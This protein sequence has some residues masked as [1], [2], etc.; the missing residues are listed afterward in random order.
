M[1][2]RDEQRATLA[3]WRGV[4]RYA[5]PRPMIE[6][7][8]ERR[9]AGDWRGACAAADVEVAFTP[10]GVAAEHGADVA[11][12][13]A[14]DLRHLAP[15]L[16]RWH[17]PRILHGRTTL[18]A[19]VTVYLGPVGDGPVLSVGT[20]TQPD[21]P[22]RLVLRFERP[23]P[24][25]R[26]YAVEHW[27][28]SRFLWDVRHT[29][30][31]LSFYGDGTRLPFLRPDGTPL[32]DAELPDADPGPD[33]VV[34]AAEW[35]AGDLRAELAAAGIAAG[36]TD[37]RLRALFVNAPLLA[38][39]AGRYERVMLGREWS[40]SWIERGTGGLALIRTSGATDR[41]PPFPQLAEHRWTHPADA[42]LLRAGLLTPDELHPLLR[43]AYFPSLGPAAGPVGPPR[44]AP[45][46]PV[47]VRC[48]GEWHEIRSSGGGFAMPHTEDEQRRE[49]ALRAFG[50][51]VTGCFEV[52]ERWR[53]GTGRLPRAL[54][55]QRT[56]LFQLAQHGDTE[57]VVALL[58]AGVDPHVRDARRRTL[59]H[60]LPLLDHERLLPRLLAAGLDLEAVD[61]MSQTP[62]AVAV[63]HFG[64]RALID[65]LLAA[66]ARLDPV[67]DEECSIADLIDRWRARDLRDLRERVLKEHPDAYAGYWKH[68]DEDDE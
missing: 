9:L 12:R 4:R 10:A 51:A 17:M 55:D 56:E 7:A 53:S 57:G 64:S 43:A 31:L 45:P 67:D 27:H 1:R 59:L 6:R 48:R 28:E 66:G 54:R 40:P 18:A 47:R 37:D 32:P 52:H 29:G 23:D 58:D 61:H 33:D 34:R 38:R 5:V 25:A 16:L 49:K 19:G 2:L 62:L 42:V 39:E 24:D 68:D 26:W 14:D 3:A 44:P 30:A 65:A 50:G 15:E 22:Q 21:A 63:A 46:G 35:A 13:L 8:T 20:P 41:P 36:R 60:A 11:E